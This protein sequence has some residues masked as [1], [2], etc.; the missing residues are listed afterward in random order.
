M[1]FQKRPTL[2]AIV[3]LAIGA[4]GCAGNGNPRFAALPAAGGSALRSAHFGKAASQ[5]LYVANVTGGVLVYSAGKNPQLLQTITNGAYRP[6]SVWVDDAGILYLVN[7][8]NSSGLADLPEFQPGA[9][10]PFFTISN[11]IPDFGAVAADASQNVYVTGGG[12]NKSPSQLELYPK[13]SS[14][15]SETLTVPQRGKISRSESLSFDPSGNL[16]IGVASLEKRD[17]TVFRLAAGSQTFTNLGLKSLPGGLIAADGAGKIYAGG[18]TSTIAVYAPNHVT[19]ERRFQLP[20]GYLVMSLTVDR[21]GRLYVSYEDTLY[22]YAPGARQPD[23][24]LATGAFIAGLALS[25]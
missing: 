20:H 7:Q 21:S 13:G 5:K 15:P 1:H 2:G 3:A 9:S 22:E 16:L 24:V 14:S 8:P 11:G 17:N 4:A 19:P 18:G 12:G 23:T 6:N 25:P 10:T